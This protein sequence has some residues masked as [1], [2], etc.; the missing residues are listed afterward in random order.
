MYLI[1]C[2][3]E[4]ICLFFNYF[5]DVKIE[6]DMLLLILN[7]F[8]KIPNIWFLLNKFFNDF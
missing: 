1:D 4:I 7:T 2:F 6:I 3:K 8:C 5:L